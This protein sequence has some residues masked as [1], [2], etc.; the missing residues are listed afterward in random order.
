[1]YVADGGLYRRI[2][3]CSGHALQVALMERFD[4]DGEGCNLPIQG[5]VF[6]Q[7]LVTVSLPRKGGKLEGFLSLLQTFWCAGGVYPLE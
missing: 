1:M 7:Q 6:T 3:L 2:V 4:Y 5:S